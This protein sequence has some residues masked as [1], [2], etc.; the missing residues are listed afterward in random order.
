[1][2]E[3]SLPERT[4]RYCSFC[5]KSQ[6]EVKFLIAGPTVFI[7][8]E[9]TEI[10]DEIIIEH[11]S[12]R[13][14]TIHVRVISSGDLS[15][16][17]ELA[18]TSAYADILKA[19]F[20]GIEVDVRSC[21][22]GNNNLTLDLYLQTEGLED[23]SLRDAEKLKEQIQKLNFQLNKAKALLAKNN[24][25][26]ENLR[27]KINSL[28][29]V[30]ADF[31]LSKMEEIGSKEEK[32][33]MVCNLDIIGFSRMEAT[34]RNRITEIFRMHVSNMANHRG[35]LYYNTAGDS[36]MCAFENVLAGLRSVLLVMVFLDL[37][38]V[39]A[40]AGVTYGPVMVGYNEVI[41][42]NDIDGHVVN[43]SERLQS[44]AQAGEVVGSLDLLLSLPE[45][46][47][48]VQHVVTHR[49][50]KKDVGGIRSGERIECAVFKLNR[51]VPVSLRSKN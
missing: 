3:I 48:E 18:V 37:E 40:R 15:S 2:V 6:D 33:L 39:N 24:N 45:A 9:C 35:G 10:C 47:E 7:C 20:K 38:G 50:L 8:D 13:D 30:V 44:V 31:Y 17:L 12:N 21:R 4:V 49:V 34:E 14:G 43:L 29:A 11:G 32:Y 46:A 51:N 27:S 1:M 5:G 22:R 23:Q 26:L 25:D 41:D 16:E 28:N 19:N 36:F 42:T